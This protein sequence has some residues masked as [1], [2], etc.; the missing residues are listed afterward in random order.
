MEGI[1]ML[2]QTPEI[3]ETLEWMLQSRQVGEDIL[4]KTLIQEQYAHIY[5][6]VSTLIDSKASKRCDEITEQIILAAI[7][8]SPGYQGDMNVKAWLSMKSIAVLRRCKESPWK[9]HDK[10]LN[11]QA[12]A[13]SDLI[14]ERIINWYAA[15]SCERRVAVSLFFLF[16]FKPS[17]IAVVIDSGE[18]DAEDLLEGAKSSL[19]GIVGRRDRK[20]IKDSD[21]KRVLA[22]FWPMLVLD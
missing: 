11:I 3:S 2:G 8:D 9:N 5:Q 7:E 21:I 22:E 4:V 14:T 18:Q 1:S 20:S 6:L 12:G 17:Q 15:L 13:G 10:K 19:L 16:D